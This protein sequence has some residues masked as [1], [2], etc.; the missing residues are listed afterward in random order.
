MTTT[1][2]N[3]E[4]GDII[5]LHAPTNDLLNNKTFI[6]SFIDDNI[7]D[8]NSSEQ[9][10]ILTLENGK[11]TDESITKISVLFK[12]ELK[13]FVL[14][15]NLTRG[16]WVDIE[17]DGDVPL[18][19]T[20]QI[21][22]VIEDMIELKTYPDGK[23]FYIDFAY[24]GLPKELNIKRITV[25]DEP[26]KQDDPEVIKTP[27]DEIV[28]EIEEITE[29]SFD[30]EVTPQEIPLVKIQEEIIEGSKI[31]FGESMG[32]LIQVVEV[33]ETIKRF[34][35]DMQINDL[36]DEMLS[37][38]PKQDRTYKVINEIHTFIERFKQLREEFSEFDSSG[39]VVE[40]VLKGVHHKPL[41]NKLKTLS[42]RVP[43]ILP[44]VLNKKKIYN[45]EEEDNQFVIPI[46]LQENLLEIDEILKQT[47]SV[48]EQYSL[49]Q[50]ILKQTKPYYTPFE[51]YISDLSIV[52]KQANT[53]IE[54]IANAENF[55]FFAV[56]NDDLK[57]VKFHLTPYIEKETLNV[58]GFLVLPESLIVNSMKHLPGLNIAKKSILNKKSMLLS[59]YLSNVSRIKRIEIN[60]TSQD[61]E[62]KNFYKT[63]KYLISTS[64]EKDYNKFVETIIPKIRSFV[65]IVSENIKKHEYIVSYNL[66]LSRLEPFFIYYDDLTFKNFTD[67]NEILFQETNKYKVDFINKQK[68]FEIYANIRNS[69]FKKYKLYYS[70]I[71]N[72]LELYNTRN[73]KLSNEEFIKHCLEIDNGA[74]LQS[75]ISNINF[76]SFTGLN[77]E[78]TAIQEKLVSLKSTETDTCD[79]YVISK[80]YKSIAELENDNGKDIYFDKD[81]DPTRY[82]IMES[83]ET[84]HLDENP[85][86]IFHYVKSFLID[87][88]GLTEKNAIRDAIS[89]IDDKRK[90]E[91][92][93][94]C[95]LE[96][97]GKISYYK[98]TNNFWVLDPTINESHFKDKTKLICN[99]NQLCI[100]SNLDC[101]TKENK[102][103][104][105]NKEHLNRVLTSIEIEQKENTKDMEDKLSS[106]H[107]HAKANLV[108][109]IKERLLGLNNIKL[110]LNNE[111]IL[112]ERVTSPH[113]KLLNAILGQKD[114]SKKQYDLLKFEKMY[115][116]PGEDIYVKNCKDTNTKL[117]PVFLSVLAKAFYSDNYNETL[118]Q[119]CKE[120]GVISDDGDKWVDKYSGM[121]IK[122]IDFS[123]EEGYDESGFKVVSRDILDN[124]ID[125]KVFMDEDQSKFKGDKGI[126]HNVLL[127]ITNFIGV[128]LT[129]NEIDDVIEI[130]SQIIKA[131]VP[132]KSIYDKKKALAMKKGT[133][134]PP[135]ETTY[136]NILLL[137]TISILLIQI[138]TSIPSV[139]AKKSFPGCVRS[140]SGY[141]LG[142]E[143]ELS[144]IKYIACIAHKMR[145]DSVPWNTI[146]KTKEETIAKQLQ[147]FIKSI[148]DN[149]Y[150]KKRITKKIEY[151]VSNPDDT[152]ELSKTI[153]WKTFLPDLKLTFSEDFIPLTR[154]FFDAFNK[155]FKSNNYYYIFY[156]L[157]KIYYLSLYNQKNIHNNIKL[158]K[159]SIVTNIGVPYLENSCELTRYNEINNWYDIK[160][161][162]IACAYREYYDFVVKNKIPNIRINNTN[163]K[164]QYTKVPNVFSE[165]VI[166]DTFIF[167]C[168]KQKHRDL[169]LSRICK[170]D[171][172]RTTANTEEELKRMGLNYN[173]EDFDRLLQ[174]VFAKNI[175]RNHIEIAQPFIDIKKGELQ[176]F[177]ELYLPLLDISKNDYK[178][179]TKETDN[180]RNY[181]LEYSD[182]VKT[183]IISLLSGDLSYSKSKISEVEEFFTTMDKW[184]LRDSSLTINSEDLTTDTILNYLKN[185]I[186]NIA[187]TFPSIIINSVNYSNIQIRKNL[188]LSERHIRDIQT[189]VYSEVQLLEKFYE[190]AKLNKILI[191]IINES[192]EVVKFLNKGTPL[193]LNLESSHTNVLGKQTMIE[194]YQ[195]FTCLVINIYLEQIYTEES[196]DSKKRL[197]DLLFNII[198]LINNNKQRL[199][200]NQEEMYS[201]LLKYKEVEKSEI[202]TYLRDISDELREIENVMKNN[203]LGKWSKGQT[204]GLVTYTSETYDGEIIQQDIRDQNTVGAVD[205]ETGETISQQ[206]TVDEINEE[207]DNLAFLADDDDYGERDGDERF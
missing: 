111:Y 90:V 164:L 176:R 114:F 172:D 112:L 170:I 155:N 150:I 68:Q 202:T 107:K 95:I 21:T 56:K 197:G 9:E 127:S 205:I 83:L 141:P 38:I 84:E 173:E 52:N 163:T 12:N 196:F 191:Q 64:Y 117:F 1:N 82:D 130:I 180:L 63:V 5:K 129:K 158:L 31:V 97:G 189:F 81:R 120:R 165:T 104:Q 190:D 122:N 188:K 108:F 25:R 16:T 124:D 109:R 41:A 146:K 186:Q 35:L 169:E 30:F 34:D 199:N 2:I 15:N 75:N 131:K 61:Y 87:N 136:N 8:L 69:E 179:H 128:T 142:D 71:Y 93:D 77:L 138:Q 3:L 119:I 17:F 195:F 101:E 86:S 96:I 18:I 200:M 175:V 133:K 49:F 27:I 154:S 70:K 140:F 153:E 13:G 167:F 168:L 181:I 44:V 14:Q 89:M 65:T 125:L 151:L 26:T 116:V 98:R 206:A 46:N 48:E 203:K 148:V 39:N 171:P 76:K 11:L 147:V 102:Q 152:E 100:S 99:T 157:S 198:Q 47:T 94:L 45:I 183:S 85:E 201:K 115:T 57:T 135:Y 113:F 54:T 7:I 4:L 137:S 28:E 42:E 66:F 134:I 72:L 29:E 80:K 62:Y 79:A 110:K 149:A 6:I 161:N 74:F 58:L 192:E 37:K 105:Q 36:L 32:E 207:V 178:K 59:N 91:E 185:N 177:N 144:G 33:D 121:F 132:D 160:H 159:P 60:D 51:Q 182:T 123:T 10:T 145:T 55:D 187:I 92:G 19:I 53:F 143:S 50:N 118:D 194:I 204:K 40:K 166:Y 193:L 184:N 20:G 106:Y 67:I 156:I 73:F 24:S 103:I 88:I 23:V 78:P 174:H 22:D 126:I 43:W 139:V 162:D